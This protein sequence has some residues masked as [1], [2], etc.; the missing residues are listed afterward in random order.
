LIH[1]AHGIGRS[2]LLACAVLVTRG[3][4]AHQALYEVKKYR[5]QANLSPLQR[6]R[7]DEFEEHWRLLLQ[8]T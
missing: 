4:T 2:V 5:L 8:D 6:L 7:L 3:K 1:C